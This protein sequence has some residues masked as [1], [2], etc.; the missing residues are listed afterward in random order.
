E[1]ETKAAATDGGDIFQHN[2]AA[3]HGA[4]GQGQPG[5]FPE[6]AG[7]SD[8]A[9]GELYPVQV[10]L[11]GMSGPI[12]VNGQTYDGSMPA[13]DHLSD[14]DIAAVVNY[15]RGA[16]GNDELTSGVE[17][18]TAEQVAQQRDQDMSAADVHAHREQLI[19]Q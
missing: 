8:V 11:H 3:C 10:V 1:A 13:L 19:G 7:N 16:W 17:A 5:Y 6:L 18:V 4:D 9:L 15:V 2:C 12:T 14:D